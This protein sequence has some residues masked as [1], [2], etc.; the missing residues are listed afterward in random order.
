MEKKWGVFSSDSPSR[1]DS[2]TQRR[3]TRSQ[4]KLDRP[5]RCRETAKQFH[6]PGLEVLWDPDP[7]PS[8]PRYVS[9]KPG[10]VNIEVKASVDALDKNDYNKARKSIRDVRNK[11][12][13]FTQGTAVQVALLFKHNL[14]RSHFTMLTTWH[15]V[16]LQGWYPANITGPALK[17]ST[18]PP[19]NSLQNTLIL[20]L[21]LRVSPWIPS[22]LY[23]HHT[24]HLTTRLNE[25][26]SGPRF[27]L[28]FWGS[29]ASYT[30]HPS[31]CMVDDAAPTKPLARGLKRR[32]EYLTRAS[33]K[34]REA[35]FL[36][37]TQWS[38]CIFNEV[39]PSCQ[40]AGEKDPEFEKEWPLSTSMNK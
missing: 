10:Y 8:S 20:P 4:R 32:R 9:A 29:V 6:R 14:N 28:F 7:G 2:R 3:S 33:T 30:L 40:A 26:L 37:S 18:T 36:S 16:C 21:M 23:R 5:P 38:P 15:C 17:T 39:R 34:S 19:L 25:S 27:Y 1:A 13:T 31:I 35:E 11:H 12:R 22:M 24:R